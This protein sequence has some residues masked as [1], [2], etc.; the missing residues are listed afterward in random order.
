MIALTRA[1]PSDHAPPAEQTGFKADEANRAAVKLIQRFGSAA[2][3]NIH[4]YR[5]LPDRV[6][7]RTDGEPVVV[8]VPAPTDEEL[9]A[10]LHKII[11]RQMKLLTRCGVHLPHCFGPARRAARTVQGAAAVGSE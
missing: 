3:F 8:E 11:T 4:L 2:N 10:L 9:Q 6:Y 5:L 7:R 1:P